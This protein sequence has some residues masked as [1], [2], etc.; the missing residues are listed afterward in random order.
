MSVGTTSFESNLIYELR[1]TKLCLM[2]QQFF[3]SLL[4]MYTLIK[5][6]DTCSNIVTV[7][8]FTLEKLEKQGNSKEWSGLGQSS[9]F[10]HQE[11]VL[12]KKSFPWTRGRDGFGIIQVHYIYCTFYFYCYISSA[13]DHQVPD[14]RAW[15]SLVR[16]PMF[17]NLKNDK[18]TKHNHRNSYTTCIYDKMFTFD[19]E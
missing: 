1:V 3:F 2:G 18:V 6:H 14:P 15:G 9:T 17:F 11:P 5:A 19:T 7:P 12:Q 4:E 13:S 8:L 10:W 16:W